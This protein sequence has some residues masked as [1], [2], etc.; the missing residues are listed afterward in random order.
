M[1]VV[2]SATMERSY[3]WVFF[4]NTRS[5]L[6]TGDPRQALAGNSPIVVLKAT[7]AVHELGTALP[8]EH[9]LAD[10]ERRLGLDR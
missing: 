9:A 5:Y 6:E 10:L 2:D 8:L 7:G 1:A 4:Y 3:G